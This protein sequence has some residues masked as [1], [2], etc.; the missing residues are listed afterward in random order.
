MVSRV[1]KWFYTRPRGGYGL[2]G[3]DMGSNE[4]YTFIKSLTESR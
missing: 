1:F 2:D 3:D 4:L